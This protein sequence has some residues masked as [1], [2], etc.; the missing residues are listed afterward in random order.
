MRVKLSYT[1]EV[2]DVMSEASQLLGNMGSTLQETIDLF[3]DAVL[4]LQDDKFNLNKFNDSVDSLRHNLEKID[5]RCMEVEQVVAGFSD[6]QRQE[7][8]PA[9]EIDDAELAA[10]AAEVAAVTADHD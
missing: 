8:A 6:Y 1:A 10:L 3:N 4:N 7:R 2:E 5:T 9:P